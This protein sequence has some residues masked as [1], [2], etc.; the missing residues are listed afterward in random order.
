MYRCTSC[1]SLTDGH[2]SN[3]GDVSEIIGNVKLTIDLNDRSKLH[4]ITVPTCSYRMG[5]PK[6]GFGTAVI[7]T[8]ELGQSVLYIYQVN[9]YNYLEQETAS[10]MNPE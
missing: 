3:D 10:V 8:F 9:H 1:Y 6:M 5:V 2:P 4:E 7:G